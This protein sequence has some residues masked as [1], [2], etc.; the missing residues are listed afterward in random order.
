MG[1]PPLG[2]SGTAGPAAWGGVPR[3]GRDEPACRR[4]LLRTKYQ[5]RTDLRQDRRV[6]SRSVASKLRR[7]KG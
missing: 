7:Y 5:P 1:R 2:G 4:A 6:F 3:P